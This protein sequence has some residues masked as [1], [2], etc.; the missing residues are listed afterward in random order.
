MKLAIVNVIKGST[1]GWRYAEL[2]ISG[3]V[4]LDP[5]LDITFYYDKQAEMSGME[6]IRNIITRLKN[7]NIRLSTECVWSTEPPRVKPIQKFK[8]KILNAIWG[9]LRKAKFSLLHYKEIRNF[10]K[11]YE[12]DA[13]EGFDLVFYTWPY[14]VPYPKT[15]TPLVFIPHDFIFSHF[16]G[17]HGTNFYSQEF[18]RYHKKGLAEFMEKGY[19]VVGTHY[20]ADELKAVFPGYHRPVTIIYHARFNNYSHIPEEEVRNILQKYGITPPYI[21]YANNWAH[22][23]NMGQV[24]GALYEVKQSHPSIK[25]VVSGFGT[26]GIRVLTRS[27]YYCDHVSEEEEWDVLG[28]GLIP[29]LDFTALMN[30]AS[31]VIN[32][33]LCEA[34]N[35]AGIEAWTLGVPVVMS[36]IPAF[37]D[38]IQHL[39]VKAE[40]F[41]PRN[42]HDIARAICFILDNP[43]KGMENIRISKEAMTDY[44][45][46]KWA[47]LYLNLFNEISRSNH[48]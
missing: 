24:L 45:L 40:L 44:S 30:G 46:E 41:D 42:S 18:Y 31:M 9:G 19:A 8:N 22:H 15:N 38:Q 13:F 29:G 33:S 17:L 10:Y 16:F 43:D 25:M 34:G 37:K 11:N 47:G 6:D 5:S 1:G 39:G 4:S 26:E 35:G 48:D 21:L 3:L 28:L 2:L 14:D 36:D 7:L 23:K 27:P 12:K 20:I 32:A